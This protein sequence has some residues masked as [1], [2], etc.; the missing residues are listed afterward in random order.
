MDL[1]AAYLRTGVPA[2]S[3]GERWRFRAPPRRRRIIQG[4][5]RAPSTKS[6]TMGNKAV[7]GC[8]N[9]RFQR[10]KFPEPKGGG[11]VIVSYPFIFQPG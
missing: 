4:R 5:R 3:N 11:I 7:E 10:F 6:S 8:I 1:F 9:S 2:L